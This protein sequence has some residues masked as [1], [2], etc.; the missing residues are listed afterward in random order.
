MTAPALTPWV[1][2]RIEVEGP[3]LITTLTGPVRLAALWCWRRG[4]AT[5]GCT[6]VEHRSGRVFSDPT[7]VDWLGFPTSVAVQELVEQDERRGL[8]QPVGAR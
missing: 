7:Q 8:M 1:V 6:V 3:A 4:N 2:L 5:P